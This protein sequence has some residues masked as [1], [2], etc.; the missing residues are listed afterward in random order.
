MVPIWSS[1]RWH[2]PRPEPRPASWDVRALGEAGSA[3]QLGDGHGCPWD[4]VAGRHHPVG[5]RSHLNSPDSAHVRKDRAGAGKALAPRFPADSGYACER[6]RKGWETEVWIQR[7]ASPRGKE[8]KLR[9]RTSKANLSDPGGW[10]Q[11]GEDTWQVAPWRGKSE[12]DRV[13]SLGFRPYLHHG[14]RF[15]HAFMQPV[16]SPSWAM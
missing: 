1:A 5:A 9:E 13:R 10:G 14:P 15:T 16:L 7:A 6:G 2:A 12:A 11:E 3:S 4:G 8:W